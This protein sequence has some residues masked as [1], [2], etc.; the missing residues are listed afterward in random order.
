M[1][2]STVPARLCRSVASLAARGRRAPAC[3]ADSRLRAGGG[4]ATLG[5][6]SDEPAGRGAARAQV[7]WTGCGRKG[8]AP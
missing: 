1:R 5:R 6:R 7:L 4:T 8:T 3:D 2:C